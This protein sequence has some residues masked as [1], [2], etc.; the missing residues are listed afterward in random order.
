MKATHWL[1]LAGV[2]VGGFF[3]WK[4]RA[5]IMAT[6]APDPTVSTLAGA[7]YGS[8]QDVPGTITSAVQ[9]IGGTGSSSSSYDPASAGPAM[10]AALTGAG[11]GLNDL[12][13]AYA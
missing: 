8:A 10:N 2:A 6:V 13:G 1:L 3:A 7:T 4:Y 11:A 12:E 5:N 9:G